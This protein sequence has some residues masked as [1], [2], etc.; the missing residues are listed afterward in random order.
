[1]KSIIKKFIPMIAAGCLAAASGA[2]GITANA[3][4]NLGQEATE[5]DTSS[6]SESENAAQPTENSEINIDE[7]KSIFENVDKADVPV[8]S[9]EN[10]GIDY[11]KDD[12]YDTDGNATLIKSERI[13]YNSEEMQFIAVTTKD[14]HVFYVLIDYTAEGNE[15]NV[16]FLNK[17]DDF[18]LYS[19]L[20]TGEEDEEGG[21]DPAS[22]A[23]AAKNAADSAK[24]QIAENV[25]TPTMP[26][27]TTTEIQPE[28][29]EKTS[30]GGSTM[31][32]FIVGIIVLAGG[33]FAVFKFTKGKSKSK[34]SSDTFGFDDEFDDI[35][36][37]SEEDDE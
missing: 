12:Y 6:N 4:F 20:Y 14:G 29:T 19:L 18:D 24:K 9:S 10:N 34:K 7:I 2:F 25:K 22:S 17:V 37:G 21:S 5:T 1:M 15:D 28:T 16:Y 26:S 13:I 11:Y 32:L 30:S 27:L 31:I 23:D 35:T 8:Q 36:T 33:G 3:T